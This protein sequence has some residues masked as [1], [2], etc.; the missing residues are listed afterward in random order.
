MNDLK[1]LRL[2]SKV[3]CSAVANA[4]LH[5]TLNVR[6]SDDRATRLFPSAVGVTLYA[7]SMQMLFTTSS[8]PLSF[9]CR[10]IDGGF[11][12]RAMTFHSTFI[13]HSFINSADLRTLSFTD[14]AL[15]SLAPL[16]RLETLDLSFSSQVSSSA[17]K[18]L[19]RYGRLT[20]LSLAGCLQVDDDALI[21]LAPLTQMR[22]LSLLFLEQCDPFDCLF[23]CFT[24]YD[25][26]T[27]K[28][29]NCCDWQVLSTPR[30]TSSR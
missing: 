7:Q 14:E 30:G 28:Q 3:L 5:L 17:V 11:F 19:A 13:A 8:S 15:Q 26:K 9:N 23:D 22:F 4:P 24:N 16:T 27:Y 6:H 20:S 21:A 25:V 29:V 10:D 18:S 1:A 12:T 2:T